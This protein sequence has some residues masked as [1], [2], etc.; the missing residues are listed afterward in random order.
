MSFTHLST[1]LCDKLLHDRQGRI[2][3]VGTFLNVK[4]QRFPTANDM[5]VVV[6]FR[7]D[8]GDPYCITVERPS[9]PPITIVQGTVEPPAELEHEYQ[10]WAVA[11]AFE[12]NAVFPEPGIYSIVLRSGDEVVHAHQFGVFPAAAPR[13]QE[14]TPDAEEV[15]NA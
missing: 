9:M 12:V 8:A 14:E 15:A 1:Q 6:V 10:L 11:A 4:A 5:G 7:G 2:S 3:L 13:P